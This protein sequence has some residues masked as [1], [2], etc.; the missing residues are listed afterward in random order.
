MP[1]ITRHEAETALRPYFAELRTIVYSA[2]RD[3]MHS[4][5]APRMQSKTVRATCM[6]NEMLYQAKQIF[7]DHAEVKFSNL[8][9]N[10]G[11][12]VDGRIFIRMKKGNQSL[13]SSNFPTK[14]ALAFNDQTQDLF[15]GI[16]HLQLVYV[17][18]KDETDLEKVVLVQ[19]HQN[20]IVWSID[21]T[22]EVGTEAD[23]FTLPL[24]TPDGGKVADRV[25]RPRTTEKEID[26][27]HAKLG[28]GTISS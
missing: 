22:N 14:Q 8:K 4:L 26:E 3:W 24:P 16:V 2:W 7:A 18:S 20:T 23:V 19:R 27:Q 11:L 1:F 25:L 21:L 9:D 12:L 6:W 17:L 10:R 28:S 15:Q 13:Q 5:H